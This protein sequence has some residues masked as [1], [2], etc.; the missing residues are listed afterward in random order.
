MG[1]GQL[2][3]A[4]GTVKQSHFSIGYPCIFFF[5][6]ASVCIYV[7]ARGGRAGIARDGRNDMVATMGGGLRFRSVFSKQKTTFRASEQGLRSAGAFSNRTRRRP[8]EK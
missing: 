3:I 6:F 5:S 1:N 8:G 7:G 4:C 2:V